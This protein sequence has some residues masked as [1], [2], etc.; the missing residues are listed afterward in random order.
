MRILRGLLLLAVIGCGH[1]QRTH[2]DGG[3]L[4]RVVI[5]RNG[6]AFYERHA[7][8]EDGRLS[9]RVP[10]DRVDDFLKSLTVVDPATRKPL[11]VT[12]PRQEAD[13]GSYLTMTLE[14]PERKQA[15]VLLTYVTEAPAWKP[16]YR[17]VVGSNGKVM[18]D[19]KPRGFAYTL[20]VPL[21]TLVTKPKIGGPEP[22]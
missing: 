16:S 12:I 9:V 3:V 6:V 8:V 17:V 21:A 14:T 22:A 4:G 7:T 20:D 19:Y 10:R 5:Y 15:S 11:S 1:A 13:D 18:L 2:V